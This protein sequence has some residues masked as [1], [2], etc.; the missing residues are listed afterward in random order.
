MADIFVAIRNQN[1]VAMSSIAGELVLVLVRR[2]GRFQAQ[3]PVALQNAMALFLNLPAGSY[4][5][6]ARH[7][8]LNPTEARQDVELGDREVFGVRFV[9]NE[10]RRQL[11]SI[12]TELRSF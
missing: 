2:D 3:K 7:P 11:L 4:T 10:A 6:I 12:E 9:Y 1:R 8:D 5:V